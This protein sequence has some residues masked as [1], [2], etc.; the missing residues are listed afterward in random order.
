MT[1][2]LTRPEVQAEGD[3]T[4]RVYQYAKQRRTRLFFPMRM[5]IYNAKET[6]GHE[7][8]PDEISKEKVVLFIE[9]HFR[10]HLY[11][12][13]TRVSVEVGVRDEDGNLEIR[14]LGALKRKKTSSC[15]GVVF[16]SMT[17]WVPRQDVGVL[18]VSD[19]TR[20]CLKFTLT[21]F[22]VILRQSRIASQSFLWG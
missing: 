4:I 7:F 6:F 13:A 10:Q 15:R 11:S 2:G 20:V 18:R 12:S 16:S 3:S 22:N 14:T 19:I 5:G 1:V 17:E 8:A 9:T 21:D